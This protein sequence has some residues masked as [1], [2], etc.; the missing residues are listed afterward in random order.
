[1]GVLEARG[2]AKSLPLETRPDD[3]PTATRPSSAR[4]LAAGKLA[5]IVLDGGHDLSEEIQRQG[6]LVQY[7]RVELTRYTAVR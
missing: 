4:L 1:M 6:L 7:L 3:G 5:V 2:Q